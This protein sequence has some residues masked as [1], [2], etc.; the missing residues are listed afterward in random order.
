MRIKGDRLLQR[1]TDYDGHKRSGGTGYDDTVSPGK[2]L[3]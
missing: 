3:V 2:P 1:G